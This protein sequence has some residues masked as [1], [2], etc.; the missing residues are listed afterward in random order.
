MLFWKWLCRFESHWQSTSSVVPLCGCVD[1]SH[2][3][4]CSVS[5]LIYF[6]LRD[7]L[8]YIRPA[9][10]LILPPFAFCNVWCDAL[11]HLCLVQIL[12][13]PLTSFL[14]F[15]IS[16]HHPSFGSLS[17]SVSTALFS[18]LT[19]SVNIPTSHIPEQRALIESARR[20]EQQFMHIKATKMDVKHSLS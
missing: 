13:V 16:S 6:Y 11:M 19:P 14:V 3:Y 12:F 18:A 8:C 17:L 15:Y 7:D 9:T 2:Q 1:N 20:G 4:W 5:C 10:T